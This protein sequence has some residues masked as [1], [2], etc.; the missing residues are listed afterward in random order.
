MKHTED[1]GNLLELKL[2]KEIQSTAINEM[3][4]YLD[5]HLYNK[6][7]DFFSNIIEE[8]NVELSLEFWRELHTHHQ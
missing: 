7:Y 8:H 6:L 3:M 1:I 2:S 5:K 4:F